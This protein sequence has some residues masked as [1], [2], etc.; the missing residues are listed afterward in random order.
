MYWNLLIIFIRNNYIT[1]EVAYLIS[2]MRQ[3]YHFNYLVV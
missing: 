2:K 3:L 1:I